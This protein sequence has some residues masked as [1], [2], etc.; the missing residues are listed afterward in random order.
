VCSKKLSKV[1]LRLTGTIEDNGAGMSQ[2][3]FANKKIGGGVLGWVCLFLSFFL[4]LFFW[5]KKPKLNKTT[6]LSSRGNSIFD[7]S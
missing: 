5:T 3:D 7:L 6:G 4:L 2:A 1:D